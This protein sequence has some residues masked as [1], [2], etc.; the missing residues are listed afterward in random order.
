MLELQDKRLKA[1]ADGVRKATRALQA[2]M[3]ARVLRTEAD[4]LTAELAGIVERE[5][6]HRQD[7]ARGQS[8]SEFKMCVFSNHSELCDASERHEGIAHVT[9]AIRALVGKVDAFP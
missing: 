1:E 7:R 8:F 3:R 4:A 5:E 6:S 2:E 9:A